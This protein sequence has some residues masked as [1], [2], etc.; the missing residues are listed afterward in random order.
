[1]RREFKTVF[2]KKNTQEFVLF[3]KISYKERKK[4]DLSWRSFWKSVTKLK[5]RVKKRLAW[6]TFRESKVPEI[7]L[8]YVS[9]EIHCKVYRSL[10][11]LLFTSC[12]PPYVKTNS[13]FSPIAVGGMMVKQSGLGLLL[14]INLLTIISIKR[15]CQE[16]SIDMVIDKGILNNNEVMLFPYYKRGKQ[17]NSYVYSGSTRRY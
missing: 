3:F 17:R 5:G 6:N 12:V 13:C 4:K 10:F 11:S 9:K 2:E 7:D 14:K 8:P 1:M 15:S 16:L